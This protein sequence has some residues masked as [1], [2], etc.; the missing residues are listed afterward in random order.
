MSAVECN[1]KDPRGRV[2]LVGAGPGDPALI[3]LRGIECLERADLVLYDY[4]V[5]PEILE[6]APPT[7]E[8]VCLGRHGQ[9]R[10]MSQEEICRSLV[11]AAQEGRTVVRLKGGDPAVFAH[12]AEEAVALAGAGIR[13]EIVPG[14]TAA[15]AAGSCAGIPITDR[16]LASA[17]AFV[18]GQQG[19][20]KQDP[21]LDIAS[22]AGFPGTLVV[23]M[24]ITTSGDW[25]T[26]LIDAGM[27]AG[28]PAAIVHRC[29]WPDQRVV[30]CQ[31]GDIP[32]TI[33]GQRIR[34]PAII[35]V[36]PVARP[37]K[38]MDWFTTRPLF[39]QTVLVTRPR[40]Q[41]APMRQG[42]AE[43]G[44]RVRSM[45][46]IEI[47]DPPDWQPVDRAIAQL[48]SYDW[49][50][51][52]SGNGVRYFLDRLLE[53]GRDLR[54]LGGVRLAVIGPGTAAA[55]R[56]YHLQPDVQP[57]EFRAEAL[58]EALEPEARGQRFLLIRASRGRDVL[59]RRLTAAGAQVEQAVAYTSRD[60][61][62]A[63]PEVIT[64]LRAGEIHWTTVTSSATARALVRLLGDDLRKTRLATI[65]P[66]TSDAL[67]ELGYE[68]AAE[69]RSFT[70][71]GV[72]DALVRQHED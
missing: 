2:Y 66:I 71:E 61:A 40:D 4:L 16:E 19:R 36:G 64:A 44:A 12:G 63:P 46:A 56:R 59:P 18:T 35:V 58:A 28:T 23:Y 47:A 20:D 24:G 1:V 38:T 67:R 9:G 22:L 11:R 72:I 5:N 26:A 21:P 69:A 45:A 43:L 37:D 42:L 49:L 65:S 8:C 27:A 52:S 41:W 53:Q 13:M 55:L 30:H 15:G 48:P 31:L 54:A 60:A 32:A 68:V 50:V 3:T 10:I 33:A 70:V 17:V 62:I 7:A 39:G 34:P 25:S 51:F 14:I 6:H 57:N 29:S